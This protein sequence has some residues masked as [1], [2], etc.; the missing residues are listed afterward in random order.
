MISVLIR[1]YS[2][3][4]RSFLSVHNY[5][6]SSLPFSFFKRFFHTHI[7]P[8]P[9]VGLH[10]L[11]LSLSFLIILSHLP[12][13]PSLHPHLLYLFLTSIPPLHLSLPPPF[14]LSLSSSS[15]WQVVVGSLYVISLKRAERRLA[16]PLR[17]R[18]FSR[19][20][21]SWVFQGPRSLVRV[22]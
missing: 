6:S 16:W 20:R 7:I 11:L 9:L 3:A 4:C 2:S 19:R 1:Y 12:F 18:L 8:R 14:S 10:F 13:L 22:V 21:E 17:M 5:V 15:S